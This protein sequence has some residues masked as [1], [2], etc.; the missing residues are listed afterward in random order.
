[1]ARNGAA[2]DFDRLEEY[3]SLP[4]AKVKQ[5]PELRVVENR[6]I[7]ER[8]MLVRATVGFACILT[9]IAAIIY[10]NVMLTELTA[11]IEQAQGQYEQLKTEHRR[12]QVEIEGK[13]SLRSVEETAVNQLGMA[14]VEAYQI[15]YVD[16][17]GEDR[18]VLAR[19]QQPTL[20]DKIFEAFESV[21]EYLGW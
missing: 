21:L 8:G 20:P 13:L 16:L 6:R 15:E 17:G 18:V 12:M 19:E 3:Y 10:N 7:R 14:K 11:D 2:Y 5:P 9:I 4:T 1:M